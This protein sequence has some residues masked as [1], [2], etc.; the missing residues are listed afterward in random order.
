MGKTYKDKNAALRKKLQRDP[1]AKAAQLHYE[2]RQQ[3]KN[4]RGA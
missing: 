4:T 2:R 1:K 3:R